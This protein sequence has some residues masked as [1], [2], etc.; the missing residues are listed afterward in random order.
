[1]LMI[2][3]IVCKGTNDADPQQQLEACSDNIA[4]W[5]KANKLTVNV[6]KTE[7]MIFETNHV[8]EKCSNVNV[9][10]DGNVN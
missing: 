4:N 6:D 9:I 3:H 8:I 1:M 5:F 10:Y 2:H 7:L